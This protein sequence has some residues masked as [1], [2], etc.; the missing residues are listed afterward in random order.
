MQAF[1]KA[2]EDVAVWL[3]PIG[4]PLLII[5][6]AV[7]GICM[8]IPSEEFHSKATK[9]IPWALLGF[10]V[11]FAAVEIGAGFSSNFK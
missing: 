7:A 3:K 11:L 8:M 4:K 9:I 2:F 6:L 5:V 10:A 1:L